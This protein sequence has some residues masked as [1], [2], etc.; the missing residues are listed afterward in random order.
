MNIIY[1]VDFKSPQ[2]NSDF[3]ISNA[4]ISEHTILLVTSKE[5]L[6]ASIDTYDLIL[7]GKSASGVNLDVN[8]KAI[9][10]EAGW[11]LQEIV[12]EINK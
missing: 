6:L 5:Q 9:Y 7:V 10:I 1:Y 12:N 2:I 8:K 4:L 11:E 3:A